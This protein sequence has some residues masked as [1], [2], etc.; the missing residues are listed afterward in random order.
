V[1]LQT[2]IATLRTIANFIAPAYVAQRDIP[3]LVCLYTGNNIPDYAEPMPRSPA[4][5]LGAPLDSRFPQ[6]Y[7]TALA[8]NAESH[9]GAILAGRGS[10][11]APYIITG[12]SYRLYPPSA[13]RTEIFNLGSAFHSCRAMSSVPTVDAVILFARKARVIFFGG[14]P[15]DS[16]SVE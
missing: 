6:F 9:D 4:P 12:W 8:I 10:A 13:K 1:I 16:V 11:S 15:Q 14:E 3:L 7:R 5:P 2:D